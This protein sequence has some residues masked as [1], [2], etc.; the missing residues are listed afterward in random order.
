MKR[1]LRL[2]KK[3]KLSP[4][5]IG[6]YKILERVG[7]VAYR[8]ALPPN[9]SGVHPGECSKE[10]EEYPLF[11]SWS[12][13]LFEI[14]RKLLRWSFRTALLGMELIRHSYSQSAE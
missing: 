12:L 5:F 9:L 1:V 6:P 13:I 4:R 2:D 8:L 10:G 14:W 3:G 11:E 7:L